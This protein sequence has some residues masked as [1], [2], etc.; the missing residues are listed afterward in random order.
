MIPLSP[1]R[2]IRD[3]LDI[4]TGNL[5]G[6]I[7]GLVSLIVLANH[8]T[9][10]SFGRFSAAM[11]CVWIL[12]SW[13][14]PGLAVT[15]I[16]QG[17]GYVETDPT[18]LRM[19]FRT[20]FRLKLILLMAAVPLGLGLVFTLDPFSIM[21]QPGLLWFIL[22]GAIGLSL[23]QFVSSYLQ[24]HQEFRLNA[25]C[26]MAVGALRVVGIG[27]LVIWQQ[28][29]VVTSLA[30]YAIGPFSVALLAGKRLQPVLET[31]PLEDREPLRDVI[32]FWKWVA[33]VALCESLLDRIDVLLVV[34]M[35]GEEAAGFYAA[36]RQISSGLS[37]VTASVVTGLLPRISKLSS[38]ADLY[39]VV[40]G[41]LRYALYAFPAVILVVVFADAILSLVYS[42]PYVE[43]VRLFQYT[44]LSFFVHLAVQP[45]ALV[46]YAVNRPAI[47]A[48]IAVVQLV[49]GLVLYLFFI[50]SMGPEG[51]G[52]AMLL[53]N[54]ATGV[55]ILSAVF[56]LL[57]R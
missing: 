23:W 6:Q 46:L 8:M 52:L 15:T 53:T 24:V 37:L 4:F 44:T 42:A 20:V 31:A 3:F 22:A 51:A 41:S 47:R 18:A 25:L 2:L 56:A 50:R 17:A 11:A 5:V 49:L 29:S 45:A 43:H 35:I 57:R 32:P 1:R 13:T 39:R 26:N 12:A 55:A 48:A 7:L 28:L 16:R 54:T 40:V 36:V 10:A 19:L 34:Q 9:P 21:E 38:S 33:V 14:D 27:L 30:I